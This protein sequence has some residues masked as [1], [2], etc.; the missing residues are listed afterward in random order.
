MKNNWQICGRLPIEH[1]GTSIK[2]YCSLKCL[3]W[4]FVVARAWMQH[5][6]LTF[7]IQCV[8]N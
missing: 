3:L 5:L 2:H 6:F 8:W 4:G 7:E 1:Y